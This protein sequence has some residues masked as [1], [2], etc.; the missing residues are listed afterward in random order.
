MH[1]ITQQLRMN[2]YDFCPSSG[3]NCPKQS[4]IVSCSNFKASPAVILTSGIIQ[5]L[6]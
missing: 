6:S 1:P 2:P 3:K 5:L 4:Q